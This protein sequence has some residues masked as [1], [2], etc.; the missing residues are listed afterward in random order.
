MGDHYEINR[1]II[2]QMLGRVCVAAG[3]LA[4]EVICLAVGLWVR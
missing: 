4:L 2:G 3:L 1:K